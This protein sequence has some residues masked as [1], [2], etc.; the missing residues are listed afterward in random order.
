MVVLRRLDTLLEPTKDAVL[1][2]VSYQKD[3]MEALELD[4]APLTDA[5]GYVFYNTSQWTLKRIHATATNN[6]QILLANIE[7]YLDGLRSNDVDKQNLFE[8][9]L[10]RQNAR[11]YGT[12]GNP[13]SILNW[14]IQSTGTDILRLSCVRLMDARVK[15]CAPVHD[16]ILIEAPLESL[17]AQV[18]LARGIMEQ[19][20]RDL[21]GGRSCR[22]DVDLIKSPE[23]YMDMK[24]GL[25]MWNTVMR[26]LG[27]PEQE[28][29]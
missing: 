6:Q 17:D 21:L 25:V 18:E 27:L 29:A 16:A 1:E 19:A 26:S 4:D 5:S 2:E 20:C 11:D 9:W 23:R 12:D 8:S 10:K 28:G 22:V 13:R 15:I 7:D 24:R 3:E 14:P